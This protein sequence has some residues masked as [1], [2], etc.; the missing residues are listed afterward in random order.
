MGDEYTNEVNR[1]QTRMAV[2]SLRK[3]PSNYQVF[4]FY[5]SMGFL[6]GV[7]ILIGTLVAIQTEDQQLSSGTLSILVILNIVVAIV[8]FISYTAY[9]RNI[10]KYVHG[11][12]KPLNPN[13]GCKQ[14]HSGFSPSRGGIA[15]PSLNSS[16]ASSGSAPPR[17]GGFFGPR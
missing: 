12:I 5:I 4:S 1:A 15:T 6:F 16:A 3:N 2:G 14:E 13:D 9:L 10:G 11:R 17:P 8:L 7:S